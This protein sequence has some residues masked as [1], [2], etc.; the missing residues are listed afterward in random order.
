MRLPRALAW[1]L[2]V[3]AAGLAASVL[4]W[5]DLAEGDWL[6]AIATRFA[7]VDGH[8]VHYPTPTAELARL[9]EAGQDASALRHLAEARLALG[10]RK[11]AL[12]AMERWAKATGPAAWAELARWA[13]AH[14]EP[15]AAFR[16]AE[17]ALPGLAGEERAALAD[18]RI[19]WAERHP[20]LADPIAMRQARSALF[21]RDSEAL[22]AWVRALEKAGRLDE[23][24]KALASAP[25]LEPERRLLLAADL[26]AAHGDAKGAFRLL[27][28]VITRLGIRQE[29]RIW[30]SLKKHLEAAPPE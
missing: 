15:A 18:A 25:A 9:L 5:E 10:D 22:E 23:A 27:G 7:M 28:P 24:D 3:A 12:E 8:R 19:Q 4:P 6:Y 14:Q 30:T 1:C 21:P 16:A 13:A 20:E 17:Q 26:R 2:A 29:E 11:G